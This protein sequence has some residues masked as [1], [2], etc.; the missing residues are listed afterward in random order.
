MRILL[1]LFVMVIANMVTAVFQ[2]MG[3]SAMC[4]A[5]RVRRLMLSMRMIVA[6]VGAS[7]GYG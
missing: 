2:P 5:R 1:Y 7:S 6:G 3:K 4:I